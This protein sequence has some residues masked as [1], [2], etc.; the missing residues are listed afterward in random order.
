MAERKKKRAQFYPQA[1]KKSFCNP[2]ANVSDGDICKRT[3]RTRMSSG[4]AGKK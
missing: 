2:C 3:L 1:I 4:V